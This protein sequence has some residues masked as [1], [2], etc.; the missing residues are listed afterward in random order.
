MGHP[1]K[2]FRALSCL[3]DYSQTAV[4]GKFLEAFFIG[5]YR[6]AF[7]TAHHSLDFRMVLVAHYHDCIALLLQLRPF[8]AQ[9]TTK[10]IIILAT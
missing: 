7:D 3:A 2:V 6:S 1:G 10:E 9:V 4:N 5:H 8:L